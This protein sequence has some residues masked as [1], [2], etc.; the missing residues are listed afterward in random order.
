ML[1]PE[2][3]KPFYRYCYFV[4]FFL[5]FTPI[6]DSSKTNCVNHRSWKA[7]PSKTGPGRAHV[8]EVV[9]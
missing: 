7:P 3:E 6:I 4:L 9:T 1:L 2:L 8:A 5:E